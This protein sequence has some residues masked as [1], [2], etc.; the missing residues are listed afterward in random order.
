MPQG[1]ASTPPPAPEHILLL[2]A[3][4]RANPIEPTRTRRVFVNRNL[5]L[6]KIEVI[7]FDMDYTLAL[8]NQ[9]RIEALSVECTLTKMVQSR[10]YP[11]ALLSLSY[12]PRFAIR[13]MVVDYERGNLL[14]MDRYGYVG[15]AYHGTRALPREERQSLYRGQDVRLR[16]PRPRWAY[17]DTLFALPEA[18]LYARAVDYFDA[19]PQF[20]ELAPSARA[21]RYARLWTDIRECIDQAHR[22]ESIKSILKADMPSFIES[23]P[24]LPA[25]LHRFR[26]A[27][28][29]LFLL[30][31][32]GYDYT[33][34]VMSYLLDQRLPDYPCWRS[35]FDIVVVDA[36][37]PA[38]FVENAPLLELS[39]S[40]TPRGPAGSAAKR[41]VQN[42][43]RSSHCRVYQGGNVYALDELLGLRG[44]RVLYV[45]DH[46]YGDMYR[47]KR[48]SVWR[49]AMIIQELEQ[50]LLHHGR[51]EESLQQ[52]E[53]LERRRNR[54]DSE[55]RYQQLLLQKLAQ[56]GTA[57]GPSELQDP[58]SAPRAATVQA[59]AS[60]LRRRRDE[61]Y[62]ASRNT[63]EQIE[64]LELDIEHIFNPFWGPLFKAGNE[65]SRLGEQVED[66]ACLYTSRV[67]N[68]LSYSPFHYFRSPREHLPHERVY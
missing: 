51:V 4:G 30:T 53:V 5:N 7:G 52:L 9:P 11:R 61:L 26:S 63:D 24:E 57:E 36:R 6:D 17:I 60:E 16:R 8:Y 27:G 25:T 67:S 58:P 64:R 23:D 10:G 32:S 28:K 59:A 39:P 49:T 40:G 38:F 15:R 29:R 48:A 33:A 19:D 43:A 18:V 3:L 47:A 68:F 34:A 22:D 35:Y 66:Y 44:D 45:G 31:N 55:L 2:E 37:K 14:K 42:P 56:L 41:G 12:D 46:I 54:V 50:E 62:A 1:D 21:E 13:G 20:Q 65:N